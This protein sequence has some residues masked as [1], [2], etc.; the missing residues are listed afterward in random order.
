[1]PWPQKANMAMAMWV[2]WERW[3]E[4]TADWVTT[5]L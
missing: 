4:W 3:Q 1:M 5:A 2:V